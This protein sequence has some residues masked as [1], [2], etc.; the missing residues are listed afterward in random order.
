MPMPDA[1]KRIDELR[2]LGLTYS[3]QYDSFIK[4]DF[5]VALVEIK[6]LSDDEW[7]KVIASFKEKLA[8]KG[9]G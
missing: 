4:D 3:F 2:E 6:T 1:N 5:N 7:A 8:A 9:K